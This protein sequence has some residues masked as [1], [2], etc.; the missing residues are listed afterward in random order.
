MIRWR[1][2]IW[3]SATGWA[4]VCRRN[5]VKRRNGCARRR[6]RPIRRRSSISECFTKPAR[7]C[8]KITPRRS[9]GIANQRN[10]VIRRRNS[11][12]EFFT[13]AA[14]SLNRILRQRPNG[15]APPRNRSWPTRNATLACVTRPVAGWNRIPPPPQ[16]GSSKLHGRE[17]KPRNTISACITRPLKSLKPPPSKPTKT[18]RVEISTREFCK[19]PIRLAGIN[20][21]ARQIP[22]FRQRFGFPSNEQGR[23]SIEQNRVTLGAALVA[24]QNAARD[25]RILKFVA[26]EQIVQRR[27]LQRKF[28]RRQNRSCKTALLIKFRDGVLA[29]R[30]KFI[31]GIADCRLPIANFS[32]HNHAAPDAE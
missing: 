30:G 1:N 2:V 5:L 28:F 18:R 20:C 7:A 31:N 23:A 8:R 16:S 9:S 26:A 15:I 25:F 12:S 27:G 24:A 32:G 17:T 10:A 14:R 29:E 19:F 11:I 21:F 3:A 6:S 4:R 22:A 13:R